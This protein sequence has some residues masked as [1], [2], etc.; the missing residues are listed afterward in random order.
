M[1]SGAQFEHLLEDK[2]NNILQ[3]IMERDYKTHILKLDRFKEMKLRWTQNSPAWDQGP[4]TCCFLRVR[5]GEAG[6]NICCSSMQHIH[7]LKEE[8]EVL[9][10]EGPA[11]A[12]AVDVGLGPSDCQPTE[13]L[14]EVLGKSISTISAHVM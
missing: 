7:F 4:G 1:E 14:S 10:G 2:N 13:R 9:R 12:Y 3:Q 8:R 5:N 11:K 6:I